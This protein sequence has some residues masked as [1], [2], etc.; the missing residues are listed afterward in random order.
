MKKGRKS[1]LLNISMPMI[2][3]MELPLSVR[4]SGLKIQNGTINITRDDTG[5]RKSSGEASI[6][7][8]KK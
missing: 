2:L 8:V 3:R 1:L 6:K 5:L 4:V 7:T